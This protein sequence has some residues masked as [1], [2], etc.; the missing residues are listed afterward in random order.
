MAGG[1]GGEF[2]T[3]HFLFSN[4]QTLSGSILA[5]KKYGRKEEIRSRRKYIINDLAYQSL[6]T[7]R[8]IQKIV[9]R[10]T[11]KKIKKYF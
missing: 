10:I 8:K 11:G 4:V 1:G 6:N 5:R 9:A 7:K 2:P 3:T